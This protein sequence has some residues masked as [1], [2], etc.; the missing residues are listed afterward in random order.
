MHLKTGKHFVSIHGLKKKK[1]QSA[2][3]TAMYTLGIYAAETQ[4]S[5]LQITGLHKRNQWNRPSWIG[6]LFTQQVI[7]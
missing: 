1:K 4:I 3:Q 6:R 5:D 2:F 7:S